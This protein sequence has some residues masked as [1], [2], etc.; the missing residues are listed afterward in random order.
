MVMHEVPA[1][2]MLTAFN[3]KQF[4][5]ST[6]LIYSGFGDVY[7]RV[8][9]RTHTHEQ[10][11]NSWL[12]GQKIVSRS[13]G[14]KVTT[15]QVSIGP[16][17]FSLIHDV[18]IEYFRPRVHTYVRFFCEYLH[19]VHI[20]SM[21]FHQWNWKITYLPYTQSFF[22]LK[23][24]D[25]KERGNTR[26]S[27]EIPGHRLDKQCNYCR[28]SADLLERPTNSG[29]NTAHDLWSLT[30]VSHDELKLKIH[31]TGTYDVPSTRPLQ[32]TQIP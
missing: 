22:N 18:Y 23:T 29:Q 13:R 24:C 2:R 31:K 15:V 5:T 6:Y 11:T 26:C 21:H 1:A 25:S 28:K 4:P 7:R 19:H 17:I 10:T 27:S 8:V 3:E 12:N 16:A 32:S 14:N 20:G 30:W 9:K